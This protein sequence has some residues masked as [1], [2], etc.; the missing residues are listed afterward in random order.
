MAAPRNPVPQSQWVA[1]Q[2]N[3]RSG[4]GKG[5]DWLLDLVRELK[6]LGF[7][8][9]MFKNRQRMDAWLADPAVREN[10]ACIVA[11][12][13]DG[14]VADVFN[15]HPG[16]RL[17]ILPLG[18]ENLL[19]RFF[20]IP[21]SGTKVARVI[22]TGRVR[23]LDLCRLGDRRFVLMAS[24]GFDA[25][26]ISR[27]HHTRH[28]NISRLSYVQPILESVRKYEYPEIRL[29]VDGSPTPATARLA[30]IVNVPIYALGLS[31][32]R[33][34]QGDDGMLD[35]RL[36]RQ[37]S[38]FQMVRYLCNLAL[39]I[40][41][42]LPDVESLTC[43]RVRIDSDVPVPIQLDGDAAGFTPAE[44]SVLPGAL[45]VIVPAGPENQER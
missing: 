23:V 2:R 7:R 40:H 41:E 18:T 28:G 35:L 31:V 29:Y 20:G 43:H 9:R 34:A 36:F 42:G 22:A 32:A 25:D 15:R 10:L 38:A 11:A 1:I 4:T 5:R 21:A 30:V 3:P 17:A 19:A 12:G 44:I 26:V 33:S 24:A 13:G 27:L 16:V 39:G 45:E 37:G 6:R 14:T 8:P